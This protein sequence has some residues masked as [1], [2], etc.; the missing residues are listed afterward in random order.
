MAERVREITDFKGKIHWYSI[1]RRPGEI[2]KIELDFQKTK[3]EFGWE[4]KI[5]LKEGLKFLTEYWRK[6]VVK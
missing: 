3:R 4:P 6:R 1:P 2:P 5:D